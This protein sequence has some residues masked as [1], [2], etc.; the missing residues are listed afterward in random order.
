MSTEKRAHTVT[1]QWIL[2]LGLL[3]YLVVVV[4]TAWLSDDAYI[5]FRTVDN[6]IHG[7]GLRWNIAERVQ[8]YTHPLWMFVVSGVY[9]FTREIYFSVIA[10][11]IVLS[12]AAVWMVTRISRDI[13]SSVFALLALILSKAFIDYST[14]GLENPLSYFLVAL[15]LWFF[16]RYEE[17]PHRLFYLTLIAS[18][19]ILNRMDH[20]L[21]VVPPLLYAFF[22]QYKTDHNGRSLLLTSIIGMVPFIAW[23]LFSLFYYGFL[24]PNTAYSKLQ[25]GI[26]TGQLI[27]QGVTYVFDSLSRD[28]LTLFIIAVGIFLPVVQ[29]SIRYIPWSIGILLYLLYIISIGGDFM[30]GRFFS[31]P[32]F[33]SVVLLS[34]G[35][36]ERPIKYVAIGV[37][38]LLGVFGSGH[39]TITSD[40][41]YHHEQPE[42]DVEKG[43]VDERGFYFQDTG[44]LQFSKTKNL[45]VN[46]A[47]DEAM[48]VQQ[49]GAPVWGIA[50]V[51]IFGY[52][53]G[54]Q[55]YVVDWYG[56]GDPLMSRLQ[57]IHETNWKSG[58]YPRHIPEGYIETLQTG[59]NHIQDPALAQYY[60]TVSTIVRGPLFTRERIEA[61]WKMNTGQYD[62]LVNQ[63]HSRQPH[64]GE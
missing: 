14:S 37:I 8:S 58:H 6:F 61:I 44:L 47:R 4:R 29:R 21:L 48:T 5:T 39:P 12:G 28:P 33:I 38:V 18:F 23:E 17:R 35:A 24:F 63:Y 3:L 59:E 53:V 36:F 13:L 26:P 16:L 54:P 41:T 56:L 42:V 60:R 57:P 50:A 1:A 7:D 32:F 34:T 20:A 11:S 2:L 9:L 45:P 40:R 31:V 49:S 64:S 51:G 62:D 15:F 25:T 43:V 52:Y 30:S 22:Q 10:L 55:V 19:V 27:A 46:V